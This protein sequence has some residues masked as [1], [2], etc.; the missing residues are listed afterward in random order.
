MTNLETLSRDKLVEI[1]SAKVELLR[2]KARQKGFHWFTT[3]VFALSFPEFIAGAYIKEVCERMA[4]HRFTMDVTGR[5]HFKSTRNYAEIMYHI[6]VEQDPWEA[7][8]LSFSGG[9][10]AYHLQKINQL[11]ELN[12]AFRLLT[13][14]KI[15]SEYMLIYSWGKYAPKC[16]IK[17][18]G[19][20]EF[21]RGIHS[22][23]IYVD[24]PFKDVT[25]NQE[26]DPTTIYKVNDVM[27]SEL[28]PMVKKGG[29]C[30]I[31]GTPQTDEDFF[32]EEAMQRQF[33]TTIAP[34]I[35]SR[36]TK[37]ALWPEWMTYEELLDRER[38]MGQR[39]FSR[40][41]MARPMHATNSYI[42]FEQYH[43]AER[44]ESWAFADHSEKLAN[45]VVVAGFDI[46]KKRHPSHLSAFIKSWETRGTGDNEVRLPVYTQIYSQWMDGWNYTKQYEH[47]NLFCE[48]FN[49][50]TLRY[51]NTRA[52]FEAFAEDNLLHEAME[53]VVLSAR[54]HHS[55]AANL[56]SAFDQGRI[57]VVKEERQAKQTLLINANL[58]A[59]ETALGHADSFWSMALA[60]SDEEVIIQARTV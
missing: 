21:K 7:H 52:E 60:L 9:M 46:G 16:M 33:K 22:E 13:N 1:A 30:R 10:A 56:E 20:F 15:T 4:E 49:V 25:E 54:R 8:Y 28:L 48:Y 17:P 42:D 38:I 32:F 2:R 55:M 26:L 40:E 14:H 24:D 44:T 29:I 43:A 27:K 19:M 36:E 34:A 57:T 12:P 51:D 58:V 41:F 50:T 23:A 53:A 3:N 35:V 59:P 47:L 18:K 5:D 45:H 31:V 6:F 37:T 11:I 39:R